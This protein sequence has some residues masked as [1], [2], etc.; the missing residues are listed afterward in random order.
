V[1]LDGLYPEWLYGIYAHLQFESEFMVLYQ[2]EIG[3]MA[4][5][6]TYGDVNVYIPGGG[7]TGGKGFADVVL[8]NE[9]EVEIYE[10]KPIGYHE[11]GEGKDQLDRYIQAYSSNNRDV[12]V[13]EGS[14][15]DVEV[16]LLWNDTYTFDP[17]MNIK[18]EMFEDSP[19]MIYYTLNYKEPDK[20]PEYATQ[21]IKFAELEEDKEKQLLLRYGEAFTALAMASSVVEEGA[22]AVANTVTGRIFPFLVMPKEIIEEIFRYG[23]GGFCPMA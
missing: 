9:G 5:E 11:T 17:E 12:D 4:R 1:D 18:Y 7:R 14:I 21:P 13:K 22:N 16:L 15:E 20:Q 23:P 19:G 6:N 3:T 8:Y 2:E 10:I